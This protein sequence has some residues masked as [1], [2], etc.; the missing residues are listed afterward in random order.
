MTHKPLFVSVQWDRPE[1]HGLRQ[2]GTVDW[3]PSPTRL[4]GALTA[5]AYG[6]DEDERDRALA[7]LQTIAESA[8]PAIHVPHAYPLD[9]PGTFTQKSGSDTA[10]KG[11]GKSVEDFL[12]LSLV[13]FDTRSRVLKPVDGVAL[14]V[15]RVVFEIDAQLASEQVAAV[16]AAAWSVPY[17]GR[18]LD[19]AVV[20]VVE[21]APDLSSLTR[22]TGTP[23]TRGSTRGWTPRSMDWYQINYE[24]L[25]EAGDLPLPAVPAVG[26][27]QPL[28]YGTGRHRAPLEVVPLTQSVPSHR[29]PAFFEALSHEV[30]FQPPEGVTVFPAINA[31][32]P[33]SDGRCLGVGLVAGG[34]GVDAAVYLAAAASELAPLVWEAPLTHYQTGP[35]PNLNAWTLQPSRWTEPSQGWVSATPYRGFPDE[36]VV[37]YV[38]A[39]EVRRRLGMECRVTASSTPSEHWEH[40]WGQERFSD[41]LM[42]WWLEIQL[43]LP[44]PGPLLLTENQR[45]GTG[46]FVP[47]H[48]ET[49]EK[50]G[51]EQS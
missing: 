46:L 19:P 2:N 17:F 33:H 14:Q 41:G 24:R 16:R 11:T 40:R 13:G 35:T 12:D 21:D 3:P 20:D 15:P 49:H 38:V 36:M 29:V 28:R 27:V 32:D 43:P 48:S 8:P 10:G 45:F 1:Y 30:G 37:T 9:L 34:S 18:S 5:G 26:Y 6:L 7:A 25:F 51:A 4:L 50:R 22:L 31:G 47:K 23:D 42:D 39:E 44:A